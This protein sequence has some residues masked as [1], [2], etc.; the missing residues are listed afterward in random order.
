M[1]RRM[2]RAVA[3]ASLC[4]AL[5]VALVSTGA[6]A[7]RRGVGRSRS[8]SSRSYSGRSYQTPRSS[9]G[10]SVAVQSYRRSSGVTVRSHT[11]SYPGTG[12]ARVS[13]PRSTPPR[14]AVRS[15]RSR[16]P[17][18]RTYAPRAPRRTVYI[19]SGSRDSRG[20]IRRSESARRAFMRQTGYPHG[21]PGYVIDHR[22]A[23]ACGGADAPSNMQWQTR[24]EATAKDRTERIGCGSRR[25]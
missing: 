25:R 23:L 9:S 24:A 5:G 2:V 12:R 21:R 18:L 6:E 22:V 20:R 15:G 11:K 8:H 14:S 13:R 3:W 19:S 16:A 7:Q 10:R 1:M 4:A 17:T